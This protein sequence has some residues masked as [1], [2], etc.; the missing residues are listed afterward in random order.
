MELQER[1]D[2][3]LRE[4]DAPGRLRLV[5]AFLNTLDVDE[6]VELLGSPEAAA[7]CFRAFGVL[8]DE[9]ALSDADVARARVFREAL[10]GL[11]Y[12]HN[13][14]EE[15]L[16]EARATL[17]EESER[18]RLAVHLDEAGDTALR[19]TGSGIDA[20]LG[21]FLAIVHEARLE[22]TWERIK[23][24]PEETCRWAFYDSSRNRSGRWCGTTCGNR[25]KVRAYR[26]RNREG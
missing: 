16:T 25:A 3:T 19:A 12:A 4:A 9:E 6:D 15:A 14:H 21:A 10:R 8:G 17:G 7:R 24:C 20:T 22:G 11:A 5:Q 2:E 13:G 1:I 18:L 26:A 23:A